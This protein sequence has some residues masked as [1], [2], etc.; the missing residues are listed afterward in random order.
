M[1]VDMQIIVIH[2]FT[3]FFVIEVFSLEI[4]AFNTGSLSCGK[5]ADK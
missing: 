3:G 1:F 4:P 5:R 2:M